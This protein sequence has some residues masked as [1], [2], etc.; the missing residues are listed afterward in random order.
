[1]PNPRSP[2]IPR[3]IVLAIAAGDMSL[4]Q[5]QRET[6]LHKNKLFRDL[7]KL[8]MAGEAPDS[9]L[10]FQSIRSVYDTLSPDAVRTVEAGE[11]AT[12]RAKLRDAQARAREAEER[13]RDEN[14][15]AEIIAG[16]TA[17]PANP[18]RWVTDSVSHIVNGRTASVPIL[19]LGDWH[20]GERVNPAEAGG[21][22]FNAA[23]AE[24]RIRRTIEKTVSLTRDALAGLE[25]PGIVCAL[26]GDMTSGALHPELAE[27]DE[28]SVFM[29]I[30]RV[31]DL[32]VGAIRALADE[33]GRVFVPTAVGNHGRSFDRKPRAKGYTERNSD[34]LIYQLVAREF[35]SDPRVTVMV[36]D[37][38]ET[39]FRVYGKTFLLSHGDML[40]TKG[41]DGI[42]GALGP[43]MR[44][45]MKTLRS[46]ASLGLDIDHLIVGHWHQSIHLPQVTVNGTIKGPDEY[47]LKFLRAPAEDPS[48]TLMIL[49][50]DHGITFRQPIFLKDDACPDRTRQAASSRWVEVMGGAA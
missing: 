22:E 43:I 15:L 48:Q 29:S 8:V 1:M 27:S 40:G 2:A 3:R 44:G 24:G 38:G 34:W 5:A 31:R 35:A 13:S 30:L 37:A 45:S 21:Y 4:L 11:V 10:R 42:I 20:Y 6:G 9:L 23:I 7:A 47:A 32:I 36:P 12:L 39:V 19:C 16:L 41:G 33:F 18:P 25:Y 49:H 46:V 50:P 26:L 17:A 28:Y 14:S